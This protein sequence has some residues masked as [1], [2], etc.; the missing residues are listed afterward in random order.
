MPATMAVTPMAMLS[1]AVANGAT[2]EVLKELMALTERWEKNEA[3]KA[4]DA[5][6]AAAK[7]EMPIIAKN[8]KVGFD[9][10]KPGATR[11]DYRHEDLAEI[12]RTIDPILGRHGL[13]YRFRTRNLPNEPIS[14]TCILAHKMG[15]FEEN[16]LCGPRDDSG[17]KNQ[18]QATGST[19]TYLERYA[20]KASLGL[21][22]SND[23]DGA[24]AGGGTASADDI[25]SDQ[26]SRLV[27]IAKEVGADGGKFLKLMSRLAGRAE[28]EPLE[29]F[30]DIP[31]R[32]YDTA[33]AMLEKK[34]GAK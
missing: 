29:S 15:H 23:D 13:S 10:K 27:Q 26:V 7:A 24:A 18:N 9:S 33:L 20:L 6:I 17:N 4:F 34:R 31:P 1:Q 11:T 25:S 12:A 5:A 22:A 30:A 3:R 8:R 2:I 19:V 21:A 32:L 16:T 28:D 14:V